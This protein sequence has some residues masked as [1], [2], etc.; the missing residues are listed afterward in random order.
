MSGI[1]STKIYGNGN[2]YGQN[3][4]LDSLGNSY[5]L[6]NYTNGP[7]TIYNSDDSASGLTLPSNGSPQA[8]FI[9]KYNSNGIAQWFIRATGTSSNQGES[10]SIDSTGNIYITGFCGS[11][12]T[13]F[14]NSDETFFNS[15]PLGSGSAECFIAKYNTSGFGEWITRISGSSYDSGT[16]IVSDESGNTYVT[17]LYTS[18]PLTIYNEDGSVFNTLTLSGSQGCFIVKYNTNGNAE[19]MTRIDG[20]G[21]ENGRS[22]CIDPS[23]NLYVTGTYTSNPVIIY[24]ET[25]DEFISL[26]LTGSPTN[27]FLVKFN[28]I[29]QGI[30]ATKIEANFSSSLTSDSSGNIYMTGYYIT[31]PL[32]IYN[33]DGVISSITLTKDADSACFILKYNSDGTA[34]WASKLDGPSGSSIYGNYIKSDSSGNSYVTGIYQDGEAYVYSSNGTLFKILSSITNLPSCFIVKYDT[35]GTVQWSTRIS[36]QSSY[37]TGYGINIDSSEN[38]YVVGS[39]NGETIAYNYDSTVFQTITGE[40]SEECFIIKYSNP[41]VPPPRLPAISGPRWSYAIPFRVSNR[42]SMSRMPPRRSLV[43]TNNILPQISP[44]I[45]CYKSPNNNNCYQ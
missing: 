6:G 7:V 19:W 15:L 43:L 3:I 32:V 16:S 38:V 29:G 23:G 14:Y 20:T 9:V 4:I 31:N 26:T 33:S 1:W 17:G 34:Q 30:W 22:L 18:N 2:D 8:I 37:T 27:C 10:I 24:N 5:V 36:S 39:F 13:S 12:V 41:V 42:F 35:N 25:G 45:D 40:I 28:S 44:W 11:S 21:L